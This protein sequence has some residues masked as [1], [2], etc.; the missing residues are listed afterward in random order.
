M[1]EEITSNGATLAY[2]IGSSSSQ[3]KTHFPTPPHMELQVG[4]VVYPAGGVIAAHRH[5]PV[6]RKIQGTCEVIIVRQ[7]RC[8]VDLY[9]ENPQP[10]TTRELRQGDVLVVVSGGH[11]F[12]MK[13][14]TVL[15]EVKQGPYLGASEKEPLQ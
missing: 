11:G 9:A 7:G 6:S 15:L 8:E 1:I 5:P 14:D 3:E 2:I 13:E 4:F 12:R 10:V